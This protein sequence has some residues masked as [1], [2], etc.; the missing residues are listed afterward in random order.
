MAINDWSWIL[1]APS[2]AC[3]RWL[4]ASRRSPNSLLWMKGPSTNPFLICSGSWHIQSWMF[5]CSILILSL[6]RACTFLQPWRKSGLRFGY[7]DRTAL[8]SMEETE[9]GKQRNV[10]NGCRCLRFTLVSSCTWEIMFKITF[11]PA[12]YVAA[13]SVHFWWLIDELLLKLMSTAVVMLNLYYEC[14]FVL[15]NLNKAMS[16]KAGLVCLYRPCFF[17]CVLTVM[18]S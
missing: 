13:V 3:Y 6:M 8:S 11:L 15:C 5:R 1:S 7:A 2:N 16:I 10:V 9:R 4:A 18:A 14:L 17:P 12:M